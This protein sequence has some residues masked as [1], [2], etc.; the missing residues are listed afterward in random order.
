MR[1]L[2]NKDNNKE[3][4]KMTGKERQLPESIGHGTV[5]IS[6]LLITKGI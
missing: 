6:T 5:N 4:K 1:S 3:G 2:S